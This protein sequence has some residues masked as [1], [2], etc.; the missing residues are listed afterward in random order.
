MEGLPRTPLEKELPS[1][2]WGA[3]EWLLLQ[4]LRIRHSGRPSCSISA[5]PTLCLGSS[6]PVT[7]PGSRTRPGHSCQHNW[8]PSRSDLC[9][10]ALLGWGKGPQGCTAVGAIS[11]QSSFPSSFTGVRPTLRLKIFPAYPCSLSPLLFRG[12]ISGTF[13]FVVTS[14]S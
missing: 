3:R 4:P 8:Q 13:I 10:R 14:A 5:E 11:H 2:L 9:A 7:E 1:Q 6:Q 12:I